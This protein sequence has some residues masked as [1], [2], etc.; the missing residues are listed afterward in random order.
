M[1]SA[2]DVTKPHA[3]CIPYPAQ[4]HINPML[5]LAKLLY[6]KGFHITFVNTEY[7]HRRL[8][9]SRGPDSLNGLPDFQFKTIPDGLPP[10]D[11]DTTQDI[12]SLCESTRKNCAV[13]LSNLVTELNN[14][15]ISNAPPVSCIVSDGTMSFTLKVS[16]DLS[17]PLVFFWTLGAFGWTDPNDFMIN[18]VIGETER[19]YK[20]SAVI[21][22]TFDVFEQEVL[23]AIKYELTPPLPPIYSIGPLHLLLKPVSE[24]ALESTGSNLREE[25]TESLEWL[26][27]KEPNSVV[28]VNFGSI[29]VMTSHQLIEFAWGLANSKHSFLWVIRPDIVIGDSAI[30]PPEFITETKERSLLVSWCPQEQVLNHPSIGGFLTHCGWNSI[31]ESVCAGVAM[32]CWP[33]FAEQQTNCRYLCSKWGI[34]MEIDNNVKRDEIESLVRELMQGDKG[35]EMKLKAI[36]WK[37]SAEEATA[38]GRSSHLNLDKLIDQMLL[39]STANISV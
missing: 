16:Q 28:Y 6:Q 20:A 17:I 19:S 39:S 38:R 10:T 27:S 11:T 31:L 23:D 13:P 5:K 12:P 32:I 29:T 30:L 35:M 7:N 26:N 24:S 4:G 1:G 3:V 22:N 8:L 18:Y 14:T 25:K 36:E 9:K 37:K 15:S 21:L 2:S 34:G 33:F